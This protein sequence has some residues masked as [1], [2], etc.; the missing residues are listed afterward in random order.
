MRSS[1]V[2]TTDVVSTQTSVLQTE[3]RQSECTYRLELQIAI[4]SCL[5]PQSTQMPV[6]QQN[7]NRQ[8][9]VSRT[10]LSTACRM[11]EESVSRTLLSS[12]SLNA[13]PFTWGPQCM[14]RVESSTGLLHEVM[15][16]KV[17]DIIGRSSRDVHLHRASSKLLVL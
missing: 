1:C 5:A 3:R 4:V 6:F 2:S 9:A 15:A 14:P 10:S 13:E 8:S 16:K 7:P 11:L 17:L 12:E